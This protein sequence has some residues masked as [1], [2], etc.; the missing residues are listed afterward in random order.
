MGKEHE[1][2]E[3]LTQEELEA[4]DAEELP[5]REALSVIGPLPGNPGS[6]AASDLPEIVD[7]PE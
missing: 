2:V 6:D 4:L 5:N 7:A 3:E 1:K